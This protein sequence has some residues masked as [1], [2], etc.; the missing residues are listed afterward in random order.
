MSRL[1]IG[2]LLAVAAVAG[3]SSDE[4]AVVPAAGGAGGA[5]GSTAGAGG[6]A[7]GT[8]GG[9]DGA[10][11]ADGN[12]TFADATAD[13]S[14]DSADTDA[15]A[16][17]TG[18]T[19]DAD[20]TAAD[21]GSTA[22][23]DGTA[24]DDGAADS[25]NCVKGGT[26]PT[27]LPFAV[28]EFFYPGGIMGNTAA[29][30]FTFTCANP[31]DAGTA[32]PKAKCYDITFTPNPD[33]GSGWGGVDWQYP[34]GNWGAGAGL[35]IP[36]GATSVQF[37]AWGSAGGEVVT[38]TVGY[39]AEDGFQKTLA[40]QV[41]TTT[42]TTYSIDIIGTEYTCSTVR[43]GFGWI[44]EPLANGNAAIGFHIADIRWK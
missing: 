16:A 22:D 17:D 3:C 30:K 6:S 36:A 18:S 21:T 19:A 8:D 42:P 43:M 27:A 25:A 40:A 7:A 29:I 34:R 24:G 2:I 11:D 35:T 31:P 23:A 39:P 32:L 13:T 33:A 44:V 28:D 5:G 10:A 4:T 1:S 14:V 26:G 15:T 12:T 37:V 38:F 9:V 20:A 41:L